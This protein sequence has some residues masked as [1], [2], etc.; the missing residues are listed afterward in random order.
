MFEEVRRLFNDSLGLRVQPEAVL[1]ETFAFLMKR[2]AAYEPKSLWEIDTATLPAPLQSY[3]KEVRQ[4]ADRHI[5]PYA[6]EADETKSIQ[7][8]NR[9]LEAAAKAGFFS[10][11]LP[12]PL[13][14]VPWN[15]Y[16]H[17]FHFAASI[18]MEE[19]CAAGGGLGLMIGAHSLGMAPLLLSGDWN[20]FRNVILPIMSKNKAG[21]PTIAAYAITEPGAGSDAEDTE[22]S[23][24]ATP[25][26]RATKVR[27]GWKLNGRKVFISGGDI[28]SVVATFAA[29]ENEGFDS[30]T[31]FAVDTHAPGFALGRNE[32]KM[33]Q[34]ASSASEL[35]FEDVFVPD[36]RV[37][38]GVR[39][40]WELNQKTLN[41]S[42]MP[43]GAI[44]LGIARGALESAWEFTAKT[45]FANRR[46]L[47]YQEIG[48]ELARCAAKLMA[49][50]SM[51]WNYARE[52]SA[53]KVS[54]SAVKLHCSDT[55]ME[56]C[57][58]CM[59]ILGSASL[60]HK[61][62][63]EKAF[64]DAR[65]TQIYEGTNQINALSMLEEIV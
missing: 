59:D 21:Q 45:E 52:W 26:V 15:R 50:R 62:R 4:F 10:D 36:N 22:T 38:G 33:G 13:G 20:I 49:A 19:L 41:Y 23:L 16:I 65:L 39:K 29:I 48:S 30:W 9:V 46:L 28:A 47:D 11:M 43:V 8:Q 25:G 24:R 18:K 34:R 40:G 6:L 37:V 35:I 51:I 5:A 61:K 54:A 64:R 42:R 17:P 14:S 63:I 7:I 56:V 12:L 53:R 44:A 32:K 2:V 57:N 31:C 55:A 3:R 60:E 27:G 58:S 1:E